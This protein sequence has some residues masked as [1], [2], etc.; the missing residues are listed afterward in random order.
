[1]AVPAL[2]LFAAMSASVSPAGSAVLYKLQNTPP[3]PAGASS[4]PSAVPGQNPA[5][6][7]SR[8]GDVTVNTAQGGANTTGASA[9][10]ITDKGNSLEFTFAE[11]PSATAVTPSQGE[12]LS[13]MQFIRNFQQLTGKAFYM[14]KDVVAKAEQAKITLLGAKEVQ[15][16]KLYEFFQSILKINDLVLSLEGSEESSVWV[17]TDLK[18]PDRLLIRQQAHYISPEEIPHYATQPSV[19]VATVIA[20]EHQSAREV[21]A[22]LRPFFPDNQLETVTNIGNAS[23]LL[24]YGFG[25]TVYSIYNLLKL[26]DTP[27]EEQRPIFQQIEL[28]H[29]SA[30]EVNQILD[31]LIEK[32]KSTAVAT[33]AGGG[34]LQG[35]APELKIRVENRSNSLL[36]VG[37]EDDVKNVMEIV[38]KIDRPQPEPE[39]DF[40]VYMLRNVKSEDVQKTIEDFINKSYQASQQQGSTGGGGRPGGANAATQNRELKP[41]IVA[42]K[43]S[44]A[45][46]V[47]ASKTRWIEIRDMIE[48]LDRRQMQVLLETALIELTTNDALQLGVELGIVS[49]PKSG[50]DVSKGF[51]ISN[52]GM[53]QLIDTNNDNFADTRI[54]DNTLQGITGGILSGPDFSIPILLHALRTNS[55]S[56]VLSIPSVLV[57]NNEHAMVTSKDLVP[58]ANQT[59]SG[60]N[61]ASNS[62]FGGYQDAGITLEITPS[63]SA[64]NYLRLELSLRVANFTAASAG[65]SPNLPPPKTE[66]EIRTTVYLP[67]ES[68]MVVGGIQVDNKLESKSS[69]P[70]LGD[71]PILSWLF[72]S[73]S[74]SQNRRSL[75]F[76]ATPH[77]LSDVEFADLQNLSYQRKLDARGY[78]GVDRIRLVDPSFKPIEPGS[79]LAPGTTMESGIF[80]IPLYRSPKSGEVAPTEAGITPPMNTPPKQD[81]PPNNNNNPAPEKPKN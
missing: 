42:E 67:N 2:L 70:F 77:I 9:L 49:V 63:I 66:R 69:V 11:P 41:V 74:D 32:R 52:F 28:A 50:S 61:G 36:V 71:I 19:L 35:Q 38:A 22:S 20:I 65:A 73:H 37:L 24:V 3:K 31:D 59:F 75:Y 39:S 51:G 10:T 78:I 64:Q 48:R 13:L 47:T 68:T 6:R 15:K 58:T 30:E 40:H 53:S 26:V 8:P 79:E 76:F 17:L 25:P 46:L 21:S 1:M 34:Q 12:G 45:L 7:P 81:T 23:A 56:N 44:N 4:T 14:K 27:P 60:V 43:V 29:A 54:P 5:S 55:N 62:G 16:T 57:N 72:S 18:G 33:G 80:E